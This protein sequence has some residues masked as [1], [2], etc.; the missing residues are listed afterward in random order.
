M[1]TGKSDRDVLI[2]ISKTASYWQVRE[3]LY[4]KSSG[5]WQNYEKQIAPLKAYLQKSGLL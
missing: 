4:T 5:R 1:T 3:P 2:A